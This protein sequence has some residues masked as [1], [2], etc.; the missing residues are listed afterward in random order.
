MSFLKGEQALMIEHGADR[1]VQC[2]ELAVVVV[3]GK[4]MRCATGDTPERLEAV[5]N[6]IIYRRRF[7]FDRKAWR[8]VDVANFNGAA[9]VNGAQKLYVLESIATILSDQRIWHHVSVSVIVAE[10]LRPD[11]KELPSWEQLSYIKHQFI[12]N[13]RE[14]YVIFP[15]SDRYVNLRPVLHLWACMDVERGEVL[16]R[17]EGVM[18]DGARTI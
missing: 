6:E 8:C 12:G 5:Y 17:F 15:P 11:Q 1:C 10:K 3:D 13:E 7:C 16:P 18:K 9:W 4:C 2:G 14:A